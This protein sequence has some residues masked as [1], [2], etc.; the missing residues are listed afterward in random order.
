MVTDFLTKS[1]AGVSISDN[2]VPDETRTVLKRCGGHGLLQ[3]EPNL[4]LRNLGVVDLN[5]S[6]FVEE[7]LD[8]SDG[9]GLASVAGIGLEREPE[10]S[11]FLYHVK[12]SVSP[13]QVERIGL[14][15]PCW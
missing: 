13:R 2:G 4:R 14:H 15:I 11:D 6:A 10:N 7:V 8:K 3:V 5:T 12:T 9:G 1:G